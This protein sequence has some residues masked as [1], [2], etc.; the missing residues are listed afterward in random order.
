MSRQ[1]VMLGLR[2]LR[3]T[4]KQFND[5][6]D[7]KNRKREKTECLGANEWWNL[8]HCPPHLPLTRE[9]R[10][11]CP[12]NVFDALLITFVCST[13]FGTVPR[14]TNHI[15]IIER[16]DQER[17]QQID[18]LCAHLPTIITGGRITQSTII[19]AQTKEKEV[20][21]LCRFDYCFLS[22]SVKRTI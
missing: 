3:W 1:C 12:R 22:L 2:S 5:H 19:E 10:F 14:L 6:A 11:S 17:H 4:S 18:C 9:I 15:T 7:D 16:A 20:Y 8:V 21:L 13:Q